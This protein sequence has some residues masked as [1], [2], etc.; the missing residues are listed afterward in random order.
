MTREIWLN[1]PVKEVARATEFFRQIGF[2]F[3]TKYGNSEVSASL[4]LGEKGIIVMLF[5]EDVFKGFTNH[6][7]S[8]AQAAAELLISFD[9]G[10]PA[11]VDEM[12]KKV[13]AAGGNVFG[14]PQ[15]M[16]GWMY[17]CAF[18]DLDGHRWNMVYMD[19]SKMPT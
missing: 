2:T 4:E 14:K 9:A 8:D 7:V 13:L 11:E 12:A 15:E 3:N 19:W 10:S 6:P 18:A 16:Q 1:L 5:R 17:G